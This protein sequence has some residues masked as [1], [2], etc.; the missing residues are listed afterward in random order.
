[1]TK[2]KIIFSQEDIDYVNKIARTV[3]DKRAIT[4]NFSKGIRQ[5]IKEHRRQNENKLE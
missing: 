3:S 2:K 5:I 1:M 4:P